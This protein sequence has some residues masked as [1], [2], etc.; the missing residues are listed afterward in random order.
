MHAAELSQLRRLLS[1]EDSNRQWGVVM[2]IIIS[3]SATQSCTPDVDTEVM[4]SNRRSPSLMSTSVGTDHPWWWRSHESSRNF[5]PTGTNFLLVPSH[6]PPIKSWDHST[7]QVL[8]TSHVV[9]SQLFAEGLLQK[10]PCSAKTSADWF[11]CCDITWHG[12]VVMHIADL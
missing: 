3:I 5:T 4:S 8:T 2:S 6:C 7:S 11:F 10:S 1:S 12:F 9:L